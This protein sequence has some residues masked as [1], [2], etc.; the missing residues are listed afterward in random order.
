MSR[1][2]WE[3]Q[4]FDPVTRFFEA[5]TNVAD[6]YSSSTPVNQRGYYPYLMNALLGSKYPNTGSDVAST[7]DQGSDLIRLFDFMETP[8][9]YVGA[10]R[11]YKADANLATQAYGENFRPPFNRLSRFRDPGRININTIV[12]PE[13][14]DALVSALGNP[15]DGTNFPVMN[16]LW[17]RFITSRRGYGPVDTTGNP[18]MF[19][20]N[21]TTPTPSF[22][23]NPF[24]PA[25]TF[26]LMPTQ[27]LK[28]QTDRPVHATLLRRD[29]ATTT[30]CLWDQEFNAPQ[31]DD[32][33]NT[34]RNAYFR[35]QSY[36]KLSNM[37]SYNSNTFAVWVTMGYFE[38]EPVQIDEAHPDGFALGQELGLDDGSNRRHR[39]FYLIDRSIPAAYEPGRVNNATNCVLLRRYVE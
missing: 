15:Q 26:D 34:D 29:P 35:M 18:N 28:Q 2:G 33:R 6:I 22:F 31:A 4:Y 8:S 37:V 17:S 25:D 19:L 3:F 36:S 9:P 1:F 10:E 11:W 20:Q 12:E 27:Q 7:N 24:R 5:K 13:V 14:L 16:N 23:S 32:Y 21:S 38:V 30:K 39:A